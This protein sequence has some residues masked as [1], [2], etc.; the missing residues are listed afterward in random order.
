MKRLI[1][2]TSILLTLACK[3][4]ADPTEDT[5]HVRQLNND[6]L[7]SILADMVLQVKQYQYTGDADVDFASI[8][9]VHHQ[10]AIQMAK[11]EADWGKDTVLVSFA[12]RT[13]AAENKEIDMLDPFMHKNKPV[14]QNRQFADEAQKVVIHHHNPAENGPM[15]SLFAKLIITQYE[16]AIA[17]GTIYLKYAKDQSLKNI[18]LNIIISHRRN[19]EFL[20]KWAN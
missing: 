16:G 10:A 7:H 20:R 8:L 4:P 6:R 5:P 9:R 14:N 2:Y 1:L 3:S 12:K 18:A 15:D 17:L 13:V 19:V 11:R